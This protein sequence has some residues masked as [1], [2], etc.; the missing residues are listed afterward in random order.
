MEDIITMFVKQIQ[1]Y[2]ADIETKPEVIKANIT[3]E[4]KKDFIGDK[5]YYTYKFILK[6]DEQSIEI[7]NDRNIKDGIR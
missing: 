5:T 1:V 3:K 4:V 7:I 6:N 2:L